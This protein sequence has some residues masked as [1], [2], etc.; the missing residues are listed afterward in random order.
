MK[1]CCQKV[2]VDLEKFD[3]DID[4]T[5]VRRKPKVAAIFKNCTGLDFEKFTLIIKSLTTKAKKSPP[6]KVT[7][8]SFFAITLPYLVSRV[9]IF[10]FLSLIKKSI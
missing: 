4:K 10:T 8:F 7:K 6:P 9:Q 3:L 1:K 2:C 5:W